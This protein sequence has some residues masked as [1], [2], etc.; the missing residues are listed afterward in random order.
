M[1]SRKGRFLI[2]NSARFGLPSFHT[3]WTTYSNISKFP[4]PC[5][6]EFTACHGLERLVELSVFSGQ[7]DGIWMSVE[8]EDLATLPFKAFQ[9]RSSLTHS[10]GA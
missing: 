8:G 3:T 2:E 1:Q 5:L 6:L 4:L 7:G 9:R 10:T